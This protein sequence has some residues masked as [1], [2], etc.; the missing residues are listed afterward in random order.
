MGTAASYDPTQPAATGEAQQSAEAIFAQTLQSYGFDAADTA[1]LTSW[2]QGQI[3]G[4]G[5]PDGQPVPEAQ[6]ALNLMK[7]PQFAARFPGIIAQQNAGT[8]VTSVS[9]YL[10][11]E[12]Y[13]YQTAHAAGLPPGFM[14]PQVI[15][16]LIGSH[17]DQ[18]EL[19]D[20]IVQGYQAVAET[21]PQTRQY[22]ADQFG[23]NA[24]H[25]AAYFLDP[26]RATPLLMQQATAAQIGGEAMTL[27]FNELPQALTLKAAQAGVSANA[28]MQDLSGKTASELPLTR[29][30]ITQ[31]GPAISQT[32]LAS[33]ALLGDEASQR[34]VQL[35]QG[36]R[37]APFQG[38]GTFGQTQRG[39]AI[40][41]VGEA[42]A[43]NQGKG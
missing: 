27:G 9:D 34:A 13:A 15:G 32:T 4:K 18:Q 22:F 39:V 42:G 7:T 21:L 35:A 33:A 1:S 30:V 12:Q 14:T 24:G 43:A 25:L 11:Y 8:P 5:Q 17:V 20:R 16:D 6:V 26:N 2:A 38:G 31:A 23:I 3:T 41:A 10:S 37:V 28:G 19:S 29:N 36:A 40:G